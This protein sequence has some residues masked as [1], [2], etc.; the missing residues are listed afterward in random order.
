MP[1][2]EEKFDEKFEQS[3]IKFSEEKLPQ[4]YELLNK[5]KEKL[6]IFVFKTREEADNY[7]ENYKTKKI[8]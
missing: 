7:I 6:N 1:W 8:M 3:I 5:Y 4:I 2:V